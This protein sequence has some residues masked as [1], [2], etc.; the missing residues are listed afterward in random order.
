M[1]PDYFSHKRKNVVVVQDIN[2]LNFQVTFDVVHMHGMTEKK[3]FNPKLYEKNNLNTGMLFT[4]A[5]DESMEEKRKGKPVYH[6][7]VLFRGF[8]KQNNCLI[9]HNSFGLQYKPEVWIP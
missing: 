9:G 6:H 4:Y 8:N 3:T 5:C 1:N 2:G 7:C